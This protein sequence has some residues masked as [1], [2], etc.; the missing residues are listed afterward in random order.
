MLMAAVE[1]GQG[2]AILT[3]SLIFD[4][5]REG[6][7][8]RFGDLDIAPLNRQI[9]LVAREAELEKLPESFAQTVS[10]VCRNAFA[11]TLDKELFDKIRFL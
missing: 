3:P 1:A 4:G 6:M 10:L 5:L 8:L 11:K 2:F 9:T 7:E